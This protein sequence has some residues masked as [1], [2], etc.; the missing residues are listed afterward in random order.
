MAATPVR[1]RHGG[2]YQLWAADRDG[3][4]DVAQGKKGLV[5]AIPYY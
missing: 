1:T 3:H 5:I 2:G 4:V